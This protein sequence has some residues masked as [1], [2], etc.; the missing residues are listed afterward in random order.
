MESSSNRINVVV[1]AETESESRELVG[2][3]LNNKQEGADVWSAQIEG[4]D[5]NGYVRWPGCISTYSP[6][7]ITDILLVHVSSAESENW[8]TIKT[9][10]DNRRGIPFKFLTSPVDLSEN[11]KIL[12]VEFLSS[13]DISS[14]NITEKLIKSALNLEQTLRSVFQKIDA[15][16]NGFL[17]ES[18]ILSAATEMGHP[19]NDEDAKEIAKSLSSDGKIYFENFKKW[20]VMGRTDFQSFRK[21]IEIELVVNNFIKKSSNTFNSYLEKL[22]KEG[23]DLSAQE[24]GLFSRFNLKPSVDF[25]SASSINL[26]FT[27]GNEF[28]SIANSFPSYLRECP[29]SFGIE[30]RLKDESSGPLVIEVLKGLQELGSQMDPSFQKALS[31]GVYVNYRHVGPSVFVD[32][33]Y[34]GEMGDKISGMLSMFN[35]STLNFS[36]ESNFHIC[37][38]L[39]PVDALYLSMDELVK[40]GTNLKIEGSG[41]FSHLKT[42]VNFIV[43][44]LSSLN[45]GRL[46]QQIKPLAYLI[47]FAS[48]IKKLDF[49][50]LYDSSVVYDVI[51]EMLNSSRASEEEANSVYDNNCNMFDNLVQPGLNSQVASFSEMV[52]AFLE[53]YKPAILSLDLDNISVYATCPNLRVYLKLNVL[54]KGVSDFVAKNI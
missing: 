54:I 6:S 20:W 22:Q 51:K 28:N 53:P 17:D 48:V 14:G 45:H 50:F 46:S 10:V 35:F 16:N 3:I 30:L 15:N 32:I 9:Y 26:H 52:A 29:A 41:E 43:N 18:E 13:D 21:I 19:L 8:E 4:V 23:L 37:S 47:R 33:S 27:I 1:F 36:G 40:N 24:T 11:A 49:E 2:K 31:S 25:H 12:E 5:V 34:G 38:K 42:L 44:T 39:S 7:G